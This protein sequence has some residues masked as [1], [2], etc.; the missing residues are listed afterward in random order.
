MSSVSAGGKE[1]TKRNGGEMNNNLLPGNKVGGLTSILEKSLGAIAKGVT[2]DFCDV[3]QYGEPVTC[4]GMVIMD[5]PWY[6]PSL[7]YG[8]DLRWGQYCLFHHGSGFCLWW[9]AL[10]QPEI[11]NHTALYDHMIEGMDINCG[12]VVDDGANGATNF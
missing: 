6:E 11:S 10:T 12:V 4:K 9:Q 3:F 8:P 5:T 2:T 7:D 1:Y